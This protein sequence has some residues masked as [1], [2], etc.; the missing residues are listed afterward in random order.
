MSTFRGSSRQPVRQ[1]SCESR[2][3]ELAHG[4]ASAAPTVVRL[5]LSANASEVAA[6][7]TALC[8]LLP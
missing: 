6:S 1:R 7:A 4:S 2:Q 5:V 8:E 3:P